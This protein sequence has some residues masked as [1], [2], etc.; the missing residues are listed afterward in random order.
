MYKY[1][2]AQGM[3]YYCDPLPKFT[4]A[5]TGYIIIFNGNF[6]CS[7]GLTACLHLQHKWAKTMDFGTRTEPSLLH[8]FCAVSHVLRCWTQI[9]SNSYILVYAKRVYLLFSVTKIHH[10]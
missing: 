2:M 8:L 1:N 5:K 3:G 4:V 7:S 6:V 9:F 10:L